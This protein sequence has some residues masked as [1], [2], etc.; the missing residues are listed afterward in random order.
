MDTWLCSS[1]TYCMQNAC[2]T[3]NAEQ[4]NTAPMWPL[5]NL[6]ASSSSGK[7]QL[8]PGS[9]KTSMRV[10]LLTGVNFKFLHKGICVLYDFE[11]VKFFCGRSLNCLITYYSKYDPCKY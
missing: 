2:Y 9:F 5:A 4:S 6:V 7:Q 1:A 3:P 10:S 8:W 11:Y